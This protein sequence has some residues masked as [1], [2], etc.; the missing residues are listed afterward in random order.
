MAKVDWDVVCQV[1][2]S[3][4]RGRWMSYGDVCEAAGMS[5]SS[6]KALGVCLSRRKG[7]PKDIYRVRFAFATGYWQMPICDWILRQRL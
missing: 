7:V 5:R 1:I 6:A 4:P 3:I 2:R